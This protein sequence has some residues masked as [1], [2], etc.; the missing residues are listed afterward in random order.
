MKFCQCSFFSFIWTA[1]PH[2]EKYQTDTF[3]EF[4]FFLSN[5]HKQDLNSTSKEQN[6]QILENPVYH[7][8]CSSSVLNSTLNNRRDQD[9]KDSPLTHLVWSPENG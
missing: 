6:Q 9:E 4:W 8:Y 2:S 7:Q 5:I 1:I 3:Q